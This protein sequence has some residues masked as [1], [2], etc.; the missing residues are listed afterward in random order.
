[1][2]IRD[3]EAAP[4]AGSRPSGK[5]DSTGGWPLRDGKPEG[6]TN[7]QKPEASRQTWCNALLVVSGAPCTAPGGAYNSGSRSLSRISLP[8]TSTAAAANPM[9]ATREVS[10]EIVPPA[11]GIA[12]SGGATGSGRAAASTPPATRLPAATAP[13]VAPSQRTSSRRVHRPRGRPPLHRSRSMNSYP[14]MYSC[15]PSEPETH[16]P[17]RRFRRW[18][19]AVSPQ[20]PGDGP[21]PNSKGFAGP[22]QPRLLAADG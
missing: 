11:L 3:A 13:P 6:G 19:S 14:S 22:T 12:A 8:A 18:Q 20:Q 21:E 1:M 7:G 9:P 15:V 2:G 10:A 4:S 16:R 5:L 17:G